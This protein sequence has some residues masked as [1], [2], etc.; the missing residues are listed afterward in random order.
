MLLALNHALSH[1]NT[2]TLHPPPLGS[3]INICGVTAGS[4]PRVL[5][6]GDTREIALVPE[7]LEPAGLAQLAGEERREEL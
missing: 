4:H 6:W 2:H 1:A 7:D 5:C 3:D